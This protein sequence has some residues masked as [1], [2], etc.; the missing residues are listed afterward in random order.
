MALRLKAIGILVCLFLLS[1]EPNFGVAQIPADPQSEFRTL[2]QRMGKF[3]PDP[4][5]LPYGREGDWHTG[6]IEQPLFSHAADIVTQAL[7][8]VPAGPG[9]PRESAAEAL[10]N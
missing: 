10:K 5:G 2:L 6:D 4:C 3:S 1:L 9:S 8:A 7:N